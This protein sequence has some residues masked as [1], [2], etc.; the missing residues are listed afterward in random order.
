MAFGIALLAMGIKGILV[1]LGVGLFSLG[2][3]LFFIKKLGGVTGDVLGG[4]NELSEL[5]SLI[6]L[7]MLEPI[8]L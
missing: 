5:L 7:V 1:F 8:Q 6:L 2:Y 4:A 3:R